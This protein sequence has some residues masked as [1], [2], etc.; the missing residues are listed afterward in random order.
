MT[1]VR[2]PKVKVM[3][4]PMRPEHR[5]LEGH[6]PSPHRAD[7]VED[8]HTR[9][10]RDEH[11]HQREERQQHRAGDVHVVRP[12]R[13]RQ[14]RDRDRRVDQRLV[15]EDRLAAEHREDLGDDAE[16]RQRDDV[17]LGVTEEP[18]QVLPE[19]HAAVGRVVDVG[20]EAR[21]RRRARGARRRAPGTPS[22]RGCD[23]TRVF[24]VKIGMRNIVM[25]GARIVMIVVMK[26]TAPRIV[27]KPLSAEAEAS[28]GCRRRPARTSCST[29]GA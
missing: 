7:P 19:D 15:A 23:V 6:R 13:D 28:R 9:R 1:P 24:Q 29:S 4:K 18:E 3:R 11:R 14:R 17:D 26:F 27:P 20:A 16:E 2:P 21:G 10:H 5:R 22:A 12:H 8:L 25:P